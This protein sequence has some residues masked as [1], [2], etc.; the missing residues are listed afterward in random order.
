MHSLVSITL[1][2]LG[3]LTACAA[4]NNGPTE[5]IVNLAKKDSSVKGTVVFTVQPGSGGG[6]SVVMD[7]KL[8]GLQANQPYEWFIHRNQ[9]PKDGSCNSLGTMLS[10]S[11]GAQLP[12][13]SGNDTSPAIVNLATDAISLSSLE[14][15]ALATPSVSDVGAAPAVA[16]DST[17]IAPVAQLDTTAESDVTVNTFVRRD[18]SAQLAPADTEAS[19]AG[20]DARGGDAS[21]N[22]MALC[23]VGD[24]QNKFGFIRAS[25][26]EFN[27]KFTDEGLRLTGPYE[28]VGHSVALWDK[29]DK[30]VAC[31]TI[32][33]DMQSG[34]AGPAAGVTGW[35]TLAL[36]AGLA[37]YTAW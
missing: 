3:A 18:L 28:I 12:A 4:N 19:L 34:S 36:V 30:I 25:S 8:K 10:F 21:L 32:T 9:A 1:L 23:Q 35:S 11:G 7:V 2:A 15:T 16:T 26:S 33:T 27:Q 31:G 14:T 13:T 29:D 5:A 20:P 37:L 17:D 22:S 6:E 24:L